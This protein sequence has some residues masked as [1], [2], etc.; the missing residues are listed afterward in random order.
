MKLFYLFLTTMKRDQNND[1]G[2]CSTAVDCRGLHCWKWQ[3]LSL[4][5]SLQHHWLQ[6]CC[7]HH[8]V[9]LHAI[10]IPC[11]QC[12]KVTIN[13]KTHYKI[14]STHITQHTDHCTGDHVISPCLMLSQTRDTAPHVHIWCWNYILL[15]GGPRQGWA[16]LCWAE[17]WGECWADCIISSVTCIFYS[18]WME[19]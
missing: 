7:S 15:L 16:E 14:K 19:F 12:L 10:I 3:S 2:Y 6:C 1:C 8:S 5:W 18:W 13:L 17:S 9:A 4:R 11:L